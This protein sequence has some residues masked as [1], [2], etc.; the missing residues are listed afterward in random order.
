MQFQKI[1]LRL[2]RNW[3]NRHRFFKHYCSWDI[4]LFHWRKKDNA[5]CRSQPFQ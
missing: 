5:T 1:C 2:W 4:L 3:K